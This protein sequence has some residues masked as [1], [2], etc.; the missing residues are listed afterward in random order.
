MRPHPS[1]RGEGAA[2]QDEERGTDHDPARD[3]MGMGHAS[4]EDSGVRSADRRVIL[5]W[6]TGN[7]EKT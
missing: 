6:G 5:L 2:A 3:I 4:R 7:S 1:R